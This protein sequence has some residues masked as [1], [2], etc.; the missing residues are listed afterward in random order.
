MSRKINYVACKTASVNA[1][2][3]KKQTFTLIRVTLCHVGNPSTEIK[4]INVIAFVLPVCKVI[5]HSLF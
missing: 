1:K 2:T 4:F 3:N 5:Y